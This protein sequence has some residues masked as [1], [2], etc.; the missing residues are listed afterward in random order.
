MKRSHQL[1]PWPRPLRCVYNRIVSLSNLTLM[2]NRACQWRLEAAS[3][4]RHPPLSLLLRSSRQPS[5]P[6]DHRRPQLP[7][8]LRSFQSILTQPPRAE[9]VTW[10]PRTRIHPAAVTSLLLWTLRSP[11][12]TRPRVA[13]TPTSKSS[14][15]TSYATDMRHTGSLPSS[16]GK[17]RAGP[18]RVSRSIGN[19]F[20]S[21]QLQRR[22]VS[23]S[24]NI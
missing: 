15:Q 19:Y 14:I 23:L 12:Y 20:A 1:L 21:T 10:T 24:I 5:P 6:Q 7:A 4:Q 18:T 17:R 13:R 2:R 11:S 22:Y 9:Q 16:Y 3:C 8:P